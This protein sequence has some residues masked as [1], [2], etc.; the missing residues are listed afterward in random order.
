MRKAIIFFLCLALCLPMFTVSGFAADDGTTAQA[1][2]FNPDGSFKILHLTDFHKNSEDPEKN[3]INTYLLKKMVQKTQPD[4]AV[5]TGDLVMDG[6]REEIL[7]NIDA[8]MSIFDEFEIPVAVT[9]GNHDSERGIFTR[10]ELMAVY[11]SYPC[12]ISID[13]GALLPGCGTYTVPILASNSNKTAFNLWIVDSGDYDEGNRYGYVQTEQIEWYVQKSNALKA[14]NGGKPVNSLMFQHIIVPEIYDA[15]L[16]TSRFTPFAVKRI[17]E[18]DRYYILNPENTNAGRL[19]E[20]P[21]PPYHN[22]GQFDAIVGQGDVLAMFFG[23][24]HDNTFNVTYKGVDLVATP[25]AKFEGSYGVKH[26]G[27]LITLN[28]ADTGTYQTKVITF[29]SLYED[30]SFK[31]SDLFSPDFKLN[32]VETKAKA[33]VKFFSLISK[34]EYLFTV[35]IPELI[36][37]RKLDYR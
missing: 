9:F 29:A 20:Y 4:L 3:N 28:E 26:G 36:L 31:L 18:D 13:D 21:C 32:S 27:R 33:S 15:L 7:E 37:G 22:N 19:G 2:R 11:N 34:L 17:Y 10:E 1:Q 30:E 8:I 16:E 35:I 14:Q 25:K 6:P 12:S 5:L 24:D 23:H